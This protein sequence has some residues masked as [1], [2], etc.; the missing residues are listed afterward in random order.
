MNKPVGAYAR[1]EH[2]SMPFP[3]W[4]VD[5]IPAVTTDQMREV[6]R[7]MI[8]DFHISLARMME[9]AGRNL[10]ELARLNLG[11][12]VEQ[13]AIVVLAGRGNNGGGGL[14]AAR[15]LANWGAWVTVVLASE[16]SGQ[17]SAAQEQL[18]ILER[19]A[20][21]ILPAHAVGSLLERADLILDALVGYGLNGAPRGVTAE[22]IRLANAGQRIIIALDTPSG[23]DT[24]NGEIFDPCIRAHATLTLAL[25][26]TGL[27][28]PETRAV[29]GELYLADISVP[30]AVYEQLGIHAPY[31]FAEASIVQLVSQ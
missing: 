29:V 25:P 27:V 23:L 24:T 8:E 26:K 9:N 16:A 3:R 7:A 20:I 17:K 2:N 6:D 31:I 21:N 19:M 28:K 10:A 30:R 5:S 15:H 14:V 12:R 1:P 11:G 18:D 22:L 13:R 4:P